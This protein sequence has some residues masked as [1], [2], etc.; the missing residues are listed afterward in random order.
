MDGGEQIQIIRHRDRPAEKIAAFAFGTVALLAVT[1][2]FWFDGWAQGSSAFLNGN[3]FWSNFVL[4]IFF[5]AAIAIRFYRVHPK[6]ALL[7]FVWAAFLFTTLT[8]IVCIWGL[9]FVGKLEWIEFGVATSV[10]MLLGPLKLWARLSSK[11]KG[12]CPA[13]LSERMLV[14]LLFVVPQIFLGW[15][16]FKD[17]GPEPLLFPKTEYIAMGAPITLTTRTVL[18]FAFQISLPNG[19]QPLN[20]S[21]K[22]GQIYFQKGKF[23]CCLDST[24]Y[25]ALG[26]RD[27][28]LGPD[29][30]KA[31]MDERFGGFPVILKIVG[32]NRPERFLCLEGNGIIA[33]A[34]IDPVKKNRTRI[35]TVNVW[36]QRG[37]GIGNIFAQWPIENG[38]PENWL[39]TL[40][41]TSVPM[42]ST[43]QRLAW[44]TSAKEK[45]DFETEGF[46]LACVALQMPPQPSVLR[47]YAQYEM[48]CGRET[49]AHKIL[50][51]ASKL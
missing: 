23:F 14:A 30:L 6:A 10:I 11:Q 12:G 39:K 25:L 15:M 41:L 21:P 46:Q 48:K 2:M 7:L 36:N 40:Q 33:Y 26:L 38:P 28:H 24:N 27:L 29:A 47:R 49:V 43:N 42:P 5:P 37:E 4:L 17:W 31:F 45:G 50:E 18:P 13:I 51:T 20:V 3:K 34:D 22:D 9:W 8:S 19:I 16:R 35:L 32:G 1:K 44:A